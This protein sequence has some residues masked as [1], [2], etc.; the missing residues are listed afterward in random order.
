MFAVG[1]PISNV[2]YFAN[3]NYLMAGQSVM[4]NASWLLGSEPIFNVNVSSSTLLAAIPTPCTWLWNVANFTTSYG[5]MSTSCSRTFPKCGTY[6]AKIAVFNGISSVVNTSNITVIPVLNESI[7]FGNTYVPAPAPNNV[8]LIITSYPGV[9]QCWSNVLCSFSF[10][11]GSISNVTFAI[12]Q[13]PMYFNHTYTLAQSEV[14]ASVCCYD[15]FTYVTYQEMFILQQN[16]TQLNV[17]TTSDVYPSD[18]LASFKITMST[19]SNV[20]YQVDY[21][22]GTVD[23]YADPNV[24]AYQQPFLVNHTYPTP[25]NYTIRVFA[26]N[27]YYSANATMPFQIT[28]QNPVM[29]YTFM[30][31]QVLTI[32]PSTSVLSIQPDVLMKPATDVTCDWGMAT[33]SGSVYGTELQL[34]LLQS[35]VVLY[36][37]IDV[38]LGLNFSVRCYNSI[39]E[40]WFFEVVDIYVIITELNVTVSRNSDVKIQVSLQNN[41]QVS[42]RQF[43]VLLTDSV[44]VVAGVATGS[45]ISYTVQFGSTTVPSI[46][47]LTSADTFSANHVFSTVG[48]YTLNVTVWNRVSMIEFMSEVIV[49]NAVGN[50]TLNYSSVIVFPPGTAYFWIQSAASSSSPLTDVSCEWLFSNGDEMYTY[51]PLL[52]ELHPYLLTYHFSFIDVG[53]VNISVN[54]SNLLSYQLIDEASVQVVADAVILKSLFCNVTMIRNTSH[55]LLAVRKFATCSCFLIDYGDGQTA[56]LANNVTCCQSLHAL[57]GS[58][59]YKF[60]NTQNSLIDIPHTYASSRTYVINVFAFSLINNDTLTT[61]AVILP[62]PCTSPKIFPASNFSSN[63]YTNYRSVAFVSMPNVTFNCSRVWPYSATWTV[64]D[65]SSSSISL[66]QTGFVFNYSSNSLGYGLYNV[67]L[68]VTMLSAYGVNMDGL[69]TTVYFMLNIIKTPLLAYIAGGPLVNI[70]FPNTY[71][72]DALSTS[73]DPDQPATDKTG[74]TFRWFCSQPVDDVTCSVSTSAAITTSISHMYDLTTGTGGCFGDG[75]GQLSENSGQLFISTGN[76]LPFK[77]YSFCLQFFKDTRVA[78]FQQT[79]QVTSGNPP[80]ISVK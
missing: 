74:L 61:K 50:L 47:L 57:G 53:M 64:L 41:S 55:I 59:S 5:S 31:D 35:I 6:S 78:S 17:T 20:V 34:N 30:F 73:Y 24:Y 60:I 14:Y 52:D 43:A 12:Q 80:V 3:P 18:T 32:P 1:I 40:Q 44:W 36:N 29:N 62:L 28:I 45:A 75:P 2:A 79:L 71:F 21:G 25:G 76:M 33:R 54:C 26:N 72:L 49:Q 8:S 10:G 70:S 69:T 56:A 7:F 19:G 42:N 51:I 66:Q 13:A 22:D 46:G 38:G 67:S 39:S 63:L 23:T 58:N 9:W 11:D 48:N 68:T 27:K 16:I 4:F 65:I 15:N 77:N 37:L